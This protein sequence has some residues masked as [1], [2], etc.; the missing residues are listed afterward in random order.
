MPEGSPAAAAVKPLS[1]WLRWAL[2]V[3]SSLPFLEGL[4]LF[5]RTSGT[6]DTSAWT[7]PSGITA[8]TIGAAYWA[9]FF[10]PFLAAQER[11]WAR[12]RVAV[13]PIFTLN[14]LNVF[15][16]V[17]GYSRFHTSS[18]AFGTRLVA[19]L[20][21]VSCAL[22]PLL[23]IALVVQQLRIPGGD[24]PREAPLGGRIRT[25]LAL[26]AVVLAGVG[27]AL[28]FSPVGTSKAIWP[29]E[30]TPLSGRVVGDWLV[31]LAVGIAVV[32]RENDWSRTRP[33]AAVYVAFGA[34][35]AVALLR[36]PSGVDWSHARVWVY[37]AFLL[38]FVVAGVYGWQAG[39]PRRRRHSV[40][41]AG[42]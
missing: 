30:M 29:W 13:P 24:P 22:G 23:T 42:A 32:L 37:A 21:I 12:A 39:G 19:Y 38:S 33:A 40:V 11:V 2:L 4:S 17:M 26:Q 25:I 6:D 35:Q 10:L 14:V 36:Y 9:G 15:A 34:L 1:N 20:W 7:I 28:F 31:A 5:V 27:F 16:M 8:A 41:A 18:G 3:G